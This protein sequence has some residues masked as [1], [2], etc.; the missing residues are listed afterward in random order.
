MICA[1][2]KKVKRGRPHPSGL[3][4]KCRP[5]PVKKTRKAKK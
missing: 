1:K 3:C 2:C 5:A 4:K